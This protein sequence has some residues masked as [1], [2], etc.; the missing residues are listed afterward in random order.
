[1]SSKFVIPPALLAKRRPKRVRRRR[2][3]ILSPTLSLLA[4]ASAAGLVAWSYTLPAPSETYPLSKTLEAPTQR[5]LVIQTAAGKPFARRGGCLDAPVSRAE[6][7]AHFIDAL[8]AMED[9][10]FYMHPGFDPIGVARAAVAN[11]NSGRIVQGGSTLTQQLAKISYLSGEKTFNRKLEEAVIVLRLELGLTKD[12]ILERYLSRAYFGEGCYGL[13]SAARHY[14]KQ[15]VSDLTLAQ[16]AMLVAM[17]KSPTALARSAEQLHQRSRLVLQAMVEDGRLSADAMSGT[18]PAKRR[19][20]RNKEIG[21]YYADWIADTIEVPE[22]NTSPTLSVRTA[23]EPK[24]QRVA[25]QAVARILKRAGK[26]RKARQA[27][28]VAMRPDGRVVA[29]VG[30]TDYGSSQFNRATQAKRQP[31]SSFK[32]FVYLAALRAGGQP[33]MVVSDQPITIGDWS[34]E[35]YGRN[36]RG[37]VSL[38]QAF[39]SSINTVAVRLSEAV[40]REQVADAARDLGISSKLHVDPS[41]ALGTSEVTLLELTSAYAAFAANA[42][43]VKPWGVVGAGSQSSGIGG[44]PDGAG[45]WRLTEAAT[46]REFLSAT[47]QQGTGRGARIWYPSFGKTGTSQNYRDAWF[48]GFAGNLV[49]GVWVGNDD[50]K[51]MARVT[52]GNLPTMIW[53]QFMLR[54]GKNDPEFSTR[55]PRRI[56]AFPAKRSASRTYANAGQLHSLLV[57]T[58]GYGGGYG[59]AYA[60]SYGGYGAG[61]WRYGAR[62]P[63][64]FGYPRYAQPESRPARQQRVQRPRV[65]QRSVYR[66]VFGQE[67]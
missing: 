29:M 65:R 9:R 41:I 4:I 11:Y 14:F 45:Q 1:M 6:V 30:G 36:F 52:G 56:A 47:V 17:L 13:R 63:M 12:Q 34:P 44:M 59:T 43:P 61:Y 62:P 39:S 67:W 57:G 18:E 19:D 28:L 66:R 37:P 5:E 38:R 25:E 31:G 20:D 24:L 42:Y 50:N 40:G 15:P 58:Y 55:L 2:T 54:A 32:A 64:A 51:P 22:E 7:P 8:L 48:I 35:N 60:G 26:W 21:A 53:S 33:E 27:A 3:G 46:M 49:V 10:R 16:S 23:F